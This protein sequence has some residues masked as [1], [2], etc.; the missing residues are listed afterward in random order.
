M[1]LCVNDE[2]FELRLIIIIYKESVYITTSQNFLKGKFIIPQMTFW[3]M[4]MLV[5]FYR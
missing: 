4:S 1:R 2:T 3:E 5:L